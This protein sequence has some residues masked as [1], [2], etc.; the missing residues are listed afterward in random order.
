[1]QS[2]RRHR[3]GDSRP[4]FSP[5]WRAAVVGSTGEYRAV[6]ASDAVAALRVVSAPAI[7]HDAAIDDYS[8]A[9]HPVLEV[10]QRNATIIV[11]FA[12]LVLQG[13]LRARIHDGSW[14]AAR[15][16]V[17]SCTDLS[18]HSDGPRYEADRIMITTVGAADHDTVVAVQTSL[19]I[20]A[21]RS[22]SVTADGTLCGYIEAPVEL[23]VGERTLGVDLLRPMG[24][25]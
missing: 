6:H 23:S 14:I 16:V 22:I 1:M 19:A 24:S 12:E 7:D 17:L 5:R 3:I 21:R 9:T 11:A 4:A 13:D 10:R 25:H 15:M 2:E 8:I 20:M 18:G